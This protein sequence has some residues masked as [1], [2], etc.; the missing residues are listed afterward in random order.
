MQL[1][2]WK[3]P[4]LRCRAGHVTKALW[5]TA[6]QH[7]LRLPQPLLHRVGELPHVEGVHQAKTDVGVQLHPAGVVHQAA[8]HLG[9]M[10]AV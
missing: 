8:A 1:C 10:A 7:L 3:Q 6:G 9:G 4:L 5:Q 2:F